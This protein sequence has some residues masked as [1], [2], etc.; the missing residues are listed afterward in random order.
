MILCNYNSGARKVAVYFNTERLTVYIGI[1]QNVLQPLLI[2][3][4]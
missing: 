3:Q 2:A 4:S 1:H